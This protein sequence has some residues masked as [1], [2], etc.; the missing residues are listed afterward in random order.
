MVYY[1]VSRRIQEEKL[2]NKSTK[3]DKEYCQNISNCTAKNYKEFYILFQEMYK[4]P[5]L[6]MRTKTLPSKWICEAIFEFVRKQSYP[7]M[8]SRVWGV[9]LCKT[10]E[11]AK[12]FNKNERENNGHIYAIHLSENAKIY[13][14][15][16]IWYSLA[17]E[18]IEEQKFSIDSYNIAI[19]YAKQYWSGAII[20]KEMEYIT[21]H[22]VYIDKRIE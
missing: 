11:E 7:N 14:F 22:D 3:K 10:Y 13:E 12:I 5:H 17:N 8:P 4:N 20:N 2:L 18:L 6:I 9:F 19:K 15:N 16:M 21:E 1:H